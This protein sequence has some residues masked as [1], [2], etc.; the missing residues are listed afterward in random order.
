VQPLGARADLRG[1]RRRCFQP[2]ARGDV[3]SACESIGAP[4]ERRKAGTIADDEAP[5]AQRLASSATN[6]AATAAR[7]TGAACAGAAAASADS[8]TA[9]S[10][11]CSSAAASSTQR[12]SHAGSALADRG[13]AGHR[14]WRREHRRS[15]LYQRGSR[16]RD[17]GGQHWPA[18]DGLLRPTGVPVELVAD[19]DPT[20]KI[21]VFYAAQAEFPSIG[22]D[23]GFT[24]VEGNAGYFHAFWNSD[25]E[26]DRVF[27]LLASDKLSGDSLRHFTFEELTQSFGPARDSDLY[28]DS[29]FFADGSDGG[30]ATQLSGLDR[31]LLT[32]LY[33]Q[34]RPGDDQ[35]KVQRAFDQHWH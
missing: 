6:G 8:G 28:S 9:A 16:E 27:V 14:V 34:L 1:R 19:G 29:V 33:T 2:G 11:A 7:T 30:S 12:G 17:E 35:L 21:K 32:F 24:Y 22:T 13:H 18:L 15:S 4:D 5:A 10:N 26:I 3:R 23:N 20:A 25:F 31:K